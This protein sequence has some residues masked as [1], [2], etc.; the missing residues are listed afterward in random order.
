MMKTEFGNKPI[1]GE[2]AIDKK[3]YDLVQGTK[4]SDISLFSCGRS[5]LYA[6][7][8][9][10]NGTVIL[11]DYLCESI[12]DAV[13]KAGAGYIFYHVDASM[14]PVNESILE[15]Y[16][17]CPFNAVLLINY[18]GLRDNG[19][20]IAFIR[21]KLPEI[22][23]ITD[24]VQDQ[25][26]YAGLKDYDYAFNS[27]RKW[28]PVPDGAYLKKKEDSKIRCLMP[29]SGPGQVSDSGFQAYKLAGNLLKQYGAAV[30]E[31]IFLDLIEKGEEMLDEDFL[32]KTSLFSTKAVNVIDY[33]GA[34]AARRKNG[35]FLDE[36]LTAM[37][38]EH[39]RYD[40]GNDRAVPF[41]IPLICKDRD[42]RDGLRMHLR[43]KG[44]FAPVHWP[45]PDDPDIKNDLYDRELSLTCDQRYGPEDM[46]RLTEAISDY[47]GQ[48][49]RV[50]QM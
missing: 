23:I 22:K 9:D 49:D 33:E 21:E 46:E 5:A 32:C 2:F 3:W 40:N 17:R 48:Y 44:I 8:K 34:A 42:T 31:D 19:D 30:S 45:A 12:I 18:F 43:S 37:G 24:C 41:F 7:L 11:P 27:L 4:A 39:I 29:V 47:F 20:T 26:G 35:A 38:L 36:K 6:A 10:I 14:K 16:D 50:N 13:K 25:Y 1:G 15:A 28:F